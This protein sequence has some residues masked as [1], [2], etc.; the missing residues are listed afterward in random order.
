[1]A[2]IN[3]KK[4]VAVVYYENPNGGAGEIITHFTTWDG[5]HGFMQ[6]GSERYG[7][8]YTYTGTRDGV[9]VFTEQHSRNLE[10]QKAPRHPKA[11]GGLRR[12]L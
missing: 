12:S 4:I 5:L 3:G 2:A 11:R 1:M 7:Y 8:V 9:A 6:D 10:K